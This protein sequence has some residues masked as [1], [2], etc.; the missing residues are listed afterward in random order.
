M[1]QHQST[2]SRSVLTIDWLT[3]EMLKFTIML[4]YSLTRCVSQESS[5][6]EGCHSFSAS[7]MTQFSILFRRT[8]LSILRDS[9]RNHSDACWTPSATAAKRDN[10]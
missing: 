1:D 2:S 5:S 4:F 7:C 3:A 8:F 6:S 9:V 10:Q